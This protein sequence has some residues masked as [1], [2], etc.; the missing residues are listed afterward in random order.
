MGLGREIMWQGED[1]GLA[2]AFAVYDAQWRLSA[3]LNW[4][5]RQFAHNAALA[6]LCA[7]AFGLTN[8]SLAEAVTEGLQQI[9]L[10][11]RC[12]IIAKHPWQIVD[13]AHTVQ[14]TLALTQLLGRLTA[15]PR[16]LVFALSRDK[17][18]HEVI[19]PL[20][21]YFDYFTATQIDK[22][23]GF[24]AAELAAALADVGRLILVEESPHQAV[25]NARKPLPNTGLLCVTGSVY[26]AGA[27]RNWL[28]SF[29]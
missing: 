20:M 23:R 6:V 8:E 14:S 15:Q 10:P 29:A 18:P 26:L 11:G 7:R 19:A 27:A 21:P 3:R 25:L 22:R 9:Q 17:S 1:H 24:T 16:H 4:P 28:R 12:E 2:S 5:G 13:S